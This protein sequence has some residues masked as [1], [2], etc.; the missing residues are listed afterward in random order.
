VCTIRSALVMAL[1]STLIVACGGHGSVPAY[2]AADTPSGETLNVDVVLR[3]YSFS[4]RRF[5]VQSGD[6]IEFNL[7]S[8]DI[9]HNFTI[10]ELGIEWQV[11]KEESVQQRAVFDTLGEFRLICTIP[12]HES[13]G[14]FGLV[15]VTDKPS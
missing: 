2:R 8:I 14:M 15:S 10:Q 4:P 3:N 6:V 7:R 9:M 11:L 13:M 1:I 12:G 5:E